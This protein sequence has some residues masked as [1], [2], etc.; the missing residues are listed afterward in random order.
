VKRDGKWLRPIKFLG[1]TYE[2]VSRFDPLVYVWV[3][4]FGLLLDLSFETGFLMT[5]LAVLVFSECP[6]TRPCIRASTRKGA[7]LEFT[8]DKA[9]L[10]W[11]LRDL[12]HLELS[13]SARG[14][15]HSMSLEDWL[16]SNWL[17][18]NN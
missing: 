12:A 4:L 13:G 6:D 2:G 8:K 15:K 10:A 7:V 3:I 17:L 1:F 16:R 18:F 14:L 9:F 11:L 5:A